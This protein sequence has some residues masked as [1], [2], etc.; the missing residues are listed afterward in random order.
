MNTEQ[1]LIELR[2]GQ[3]CQQVMIEA[4]KIIEQLT[5]DLSHEKKTAA[6][7]VQ[8]VNDLEQEQKLIKKSENQLN[9]ENQNGK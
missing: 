9:K 6:I 8:Y 7:C 1:I 4:A 2:S 5:R 3:A